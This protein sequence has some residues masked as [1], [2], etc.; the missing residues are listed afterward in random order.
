MFAIVLRCHAYT[1]PHTPTQI[2]STVSHLI[3]H[4]D[5]LFAA[6]DVYE[7]FV[8]EPLHE[9]FLIPLTERTFAPSHSL[10]P[11]L[12]S[13]KVSRSSFTLNAVKLSRPQRRRELV[14][15]EVTLALDV[16]AHG[17]G[18]PFHSPCGRAACGPTR[19]NGT[20]VALEWPVI[21]RSSARILLHS[22]TKIMLRS[23]MP[24]SVMSKKSLW[25]ALFLCLLFWPCTAL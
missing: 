18:A 17:G 19:P 8:L 15:A 1:W 2:Y 12:H 16:L 10:Q 20:C 4:T 14:C 11:S 25:V 23:Q 9:A 21:C 13:A 3:R 5:G 7:D 24:G 6:C 22:L